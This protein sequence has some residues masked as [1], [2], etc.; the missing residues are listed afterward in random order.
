MI[1]AVIGTITGEGFAI[2]ELA[3][4]AEREV[5]KGSRSIRASLGPRA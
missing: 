3:D 2:F 5:A 1:M 4:C